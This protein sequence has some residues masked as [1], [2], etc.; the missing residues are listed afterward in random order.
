MERSVFTP[1]LF[2][3]DGVILIPEPVL[4]RDKLLTV[5]M[6]EFVA[7]VLIKVSVLLVR[8]KNWGEATLGIMSSFIVT[9]RDDAVKKVL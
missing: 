8:V 7:V 5:R 4:S 3:P 9:P 2:I 6:E 1:I